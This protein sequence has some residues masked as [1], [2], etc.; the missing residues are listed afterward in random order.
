MKRVFL[1]ILLFICSNISFSQESDFKSAKEKNENKPELFKK[2]D[3]TISIEEGFFNKIFSKESGDTLDLELT[4]N[5]NFK[6][7]VIGSVY[8]ENFDI[9]SVSSINLDGVRL[10]I[11]RKNLVSGQKNYFGFVLSINHKDGLKLE[12]AKDSGNY[13]WVKKEMSEIIPD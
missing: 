12:M 4:P 3:R 5:V 13:Q 1:T 9:I 6:G 2:D 10:L 8:T 11:S 7:R